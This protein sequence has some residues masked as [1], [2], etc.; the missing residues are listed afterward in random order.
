MAQP[1]P[2]PTKVCNIGTAR[3][4]HKGVGKTTKT[5][6]HSTIRMDES[7]ELCISFVLVPKPNEI[8]LLY[9]DPTR[10]NQILLKLV[11]CRVIVNDTC[12]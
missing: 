12:Q 3:A 10:L 8:L 6:N 11:L 5:T 9:L 7:A 2:G 4:L 1:I